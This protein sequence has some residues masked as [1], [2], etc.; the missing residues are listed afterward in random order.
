MSEFRLGYHYNLE[1]GPA[2]RFGIWEKAIQDRGWANVLTLPEF[3]ATLVQTGLNCQLLIHIYLAVKGVAL[4]RQYRS[5]EIWEDDH[6]TQQ[7]PTAELT[8]LQPGDLVFYYRPNRINQGSN[9][10]KWWHLAL[11]TSYE[12]QPALFHARSG[13]RGGVLVESITSYL[14][15][16][17]DTSKPELQGAKR[18]LKYDG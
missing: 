6:Y 9:L 15:A 16:Y 10:P 17:P 14:A 12:S 11:Y 1:V 7:V 4:P 18:V 2:Y 13:K 5:Q 8:T 3:H